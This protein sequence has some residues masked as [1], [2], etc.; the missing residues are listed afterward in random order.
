MVA[1]FAWQV[2]IDDLVLVGIV[3]VVSRFYV[4]LG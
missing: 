4:K 2:E 3:Q 1:L